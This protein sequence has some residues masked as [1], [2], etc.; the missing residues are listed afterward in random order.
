MQATRNDQHLMDFYVLIEKEERIHY[1]LYDVMVNLFVS[2]NQPTNNKKS[3]ENN[4]E[5]SVSGVCVDDCNATACDSCCISPATLCQCFVFS[6]FSRAHTHV[7]FSSSFD[8]VSHCSSVHDPFEPLN[9]IYWRLICNK[10]MV[11]CIRTYKKK[12]EKE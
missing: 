10:A 7:F 8:R 2:A 6:L 5:R 12:K 1:V 4:N 11:L 9:C 3:K